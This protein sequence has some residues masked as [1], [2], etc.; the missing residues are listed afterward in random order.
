M[1]Q[2]GTRTKK[3]RPQFRLV[4]LEFLSETEL[5]LSTLLPL[6]F[7]P[8]LIFGRGWPKIRGAEKV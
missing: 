1:L 3:D 4:G 6:I 2:L 7:A 8:P 5:N